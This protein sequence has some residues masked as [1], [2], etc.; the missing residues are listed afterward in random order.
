MRTAIFMHI[1]KTAGTTITS[2]ARKH[3]GMANVISHGDYVNIINN[4]YS[5]DLKD[6]QNELRTALNDKLFISG[7]FGYDFCSV[8]MADRYSFTFLRDPVERILSFYYFCLGRDPA[9]FSIYKIVQN[10]SLN[11]FLKMGLE[12]NNDVN[13]HIWNNQLWQLAHGY[14]HLKNAP[15][16][17]ASPD[18][19]EERAYANVKK[20]NFVGIV[21]NFQHDRNKILNDLGIPLPNDNVRANASPKRPTAKDLPQSTRQLLKELTTLEQALYDEIVAKRSGVF[22]RFTSYF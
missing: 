19:I 11:S 17:T 6:K 14:G 2:L 22:R 15:P 18:S 8:F 16:A 5:K 4:L 21:E 20:F 10:T 1:Q 7:H 13:T 9:Q 3:Y 12:H